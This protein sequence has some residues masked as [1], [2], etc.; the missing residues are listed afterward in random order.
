[1]ACLHLYAPLAPN[2]Q[3]VSMLEPQCF[4]Q[5]Q[6]GGRSTQIFYLSKVEIPQ[7]RN[8]QLQVVEEIFLLK[9]TSLRSNLKKESVLN[10][11]KQ[12]NR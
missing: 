3:T 10:F 9:K 1:M 5:G 4:V 2:L 7:C 12:M 6:K 8:T 11:I